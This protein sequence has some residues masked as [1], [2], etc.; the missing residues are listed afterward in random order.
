MN[1]KKKSQPYIT[2]MIP[3]GFSEGGI[4]TYKMTGLF[5]EVFDNLQVSGGQL[6][7]K[8]FSLNHL[9]LRWFVLKF[10]PF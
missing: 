7:F 9:L 3:A 4:M 8:H 6:T 2:E 1:T 10:Q 5:A